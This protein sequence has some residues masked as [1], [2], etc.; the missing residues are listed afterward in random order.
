MRIENVFLW[1]RNGLTMHFYAG[2]IIEVEMCVTF[3][4]D[5][6]L[7]MQFPKWFLKRCI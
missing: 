7:K 6:A 2:I 4:G 3:C 5:F 1:V